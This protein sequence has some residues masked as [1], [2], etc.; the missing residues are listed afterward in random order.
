VARRGALLFFVMN[1]LYKIHTYYMFSL[2][3]FVTF[4]LRGIKKGAGD[5]DK[6]DGGRNKDP[7]K[8]VEMTSDLEQLG[9][10]I[11]ER[12]DE[13][14]LAD[15]KAEGSDMGERLLDLKTS[16]TRVVFDFVRSG[17]F[18]TDKLTVMS[19]IT[20]RIMVDEGVL[21]R[22]YMDAI[23]RG[24]QSEDAAT[25]PG[26]LSKWLS[27]AAWMRLKVYIYIHI[28]SLAAT[29]QHHHA[30][31]PDTHTPAETCLIIHPPKLPNCPI[32]PPSAINRAWKMI[33]AR[34]TTV[35]RASLKKSPTTWMTGRS[36]TISQT[37][38]CTPCRGL[39]S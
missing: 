28:L 9:R 14:A 18:E 16:V 1:S 33:F 38:R 27:E 34:L 21:S 10:E 32:P 24:R 11:E 26:D 3:S 7:M 39:Q 13:I 6:K 15:T 5:A 19:L 4:F 31:I 30:A 25:L 17:L 37:R 35:S 2:N 36:G 8:E 20:L 23:V 29:P 12:V 22:V